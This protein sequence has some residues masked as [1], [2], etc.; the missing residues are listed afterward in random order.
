MSNKLI[1]KNSF[2]LYIRLVVSMIAGVFTSRFVLMALGASDY[3]LYNVVGGVVSL[4]AFVNTIMITTT[5]RFI[6]YEEGKPNGDSN[7]IFN[8]SLSIHLLLSILFVIL[9][10]TVGLY[11]IYHY[12]KI[13]EG[14]LNDA[15]FTFIFSILNT[16]CIIIGTPFQGLL[17]AKEKFSITVPIEISTKILTLLLSILLIYLPGNHLR[18]YVIFITIIHALNPIMY[19]AYCLKTYFNTVKWH[20]C[21]DWEKYK[22]MLGFTGW[23]SIEVAAIVGEN[24]GSA[25]IINRFFGTILNA[26]FG[27]AN[28]VNSIVR[29][30]AQSLGQAIIPQITKSYSAGDH[31]RASKLVIISSKFSFFLMAIPMLPILLETDFIL[32]SWLKEVPEYTITF[33]QAMLIKSIIATSQFGIG[34]L[35]NASGKIALFKIINSGITLLCLPLAYIAYKMGHPPYII[36]YIYLFTAFLTF[37]TNQILLKVILNYD[38]IE[39]LK[40]STFKILLVC[41]TVTP[42]FIIK[43]AFSYGL[44]RFIIISIISEIVLFASIYLLGMDNSERQTIKGYASQGIHKLQMNHSFSPT[45][46]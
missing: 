39:F 2:Y 31:K 36:S 38:A 4:M 13:P 6:A 12:L 25:I 15:V 3:G 34:P 19:I 32:N 28:Q 44:L 30:F 23:N 43:N 37:I 24:Q 9:A 40:R 27:I 21:R 20:L 29:S 45:E 16:V 46:P 26:S 1:I 41:L 8:I 17:V 33:V 14:K 10:L 5:Y 18:Y 7:K 35:I 42:L 11:Y 22:E